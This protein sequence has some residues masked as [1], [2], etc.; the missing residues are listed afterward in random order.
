MKSDAIIVG[1]G[2][3]GSTIA[4]RLAQRGVSVTLLDSGRL[5]G[6]ASWAA[7]GMLAPGGEIHEWNPWLEF[8]K[9][10]L[11]M[12]PA[13]VGELADASGC[14]IDFQRKG[15]VELAFNDAE[16]AELDSRIEAQRSLGIR[17]QL[18]SPGDI[19][20]PG[21]RIEGA[22]FFPDDAVVSPRDIIRGLRVVC[23]PMM[24]EGIRVRRIDAGPVGVKVETSTG[25]L[26]AATAVLAAGAWSN[27]IEITVTGSLWNRPE[28]YPV[29]GHL[30]SCE[31]PTGTLGP[32]VRHR[33]TYMV[34]RAGGLAIVGAS[35]EDRGFDRKVD[36]NIIADLRHSASAI[37]PAIGRA[38]IVERW[39]GF[40]PATRDGVPA[41]GR[42]GN[43][44]LLTAY[45]H[46]RNGILLAPATADRITAEITA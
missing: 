31:L 33:H 6:E 9:S 36:P 30:F 7:A 45:G 23:A 26:E 10:S 32:F 35:S 15:A 43:S 38:E 17:S 8:A 4:W 5:G 21:A 29:R 42:A 24:W 28:V 3:I 16:L 34:Q 18:I 14:V 37:L 12:Y 20:L 13:F 11:R 40:R 46:Y 1:A 25:T 19:G 2:I 22:R 39:L 27:S 44:A 41:I